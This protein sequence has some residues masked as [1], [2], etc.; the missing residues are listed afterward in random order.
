MTTTRPA[1]FGDTHPD[2]DAFAELPAVTVAA[3]NLK[4]GHVVLDPDF[5]TP[6]Y[7]IDHRNRAT[8]GSGDVVFF[9][10]DYETRSYHDVT[11]FAST[12]VPVA[13]R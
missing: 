10:W 7:S 8:R 3:R 2:L 1:T 5:H 11:F 12:V 4:A 9:A 6:V 13:V